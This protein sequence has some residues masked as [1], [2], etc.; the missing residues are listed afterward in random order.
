MNTHT[1]EEAKALGCPLL[2]GSCLADKCAMWR[3]APETA[4]VEVVKT[5]AN[6]SKYINWEQK[7]VKVRGACGMAGPVL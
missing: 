2:K 5:S 7:T 3:W 6:G 4:P 1:I